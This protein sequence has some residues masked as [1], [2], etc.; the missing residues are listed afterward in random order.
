MER[1]SMIL[2][3]RYVTQ[4]IRTQWCQIYVEVHTPLSS[5]SN[6]QL[7]ALNAARRAELAGPAGLRGVI[8]NPRLFRLAIITTYVCGS[9]IS[10]LDMLILGADSVLFVMVVQECLNTLNVNI[11]TLRIRTRSLFTSSCYGCFCF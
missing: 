3:G 1:S 10:C 6:L 8:K 9:Q 2:L 11:P 7:Q 4:T 5:M